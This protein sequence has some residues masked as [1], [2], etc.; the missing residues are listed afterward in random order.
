[1]DSGHLQSF[2]IVAE[3]GH[4]TRAA[5]RL[6]ITQPALTQQIKSLEA[7]VGTA[8]L[9]KAGRGVELTAAGRYLQKEGEIILRN[10][11]DVSQC[12]REMQGKGEVGLTLAITDVEALAFSVTDLLRAFRRRFPKISLQTILIEAKDVG[13]ALRDRRIDAA[14]GCS[15]V[16]ELH[17]LDRL[18]LRPA[19]PLLAVPADHRLAS[20]SSVDIASLAV[21][22]FV[23]LSNGELRYS[24]QIALRKVFVDRNSSPHILAVTPDLLVALNMVASGAGLALVP[25]SV[26]GLRPDA[27]RYLRLENCPELL[28]QHALYTRRVET[29]AAVQSLKKLARMQTSTPAKSRSDVRTMVPA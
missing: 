22:P 3:E 19:P 15:T 26:N 17:D 13:L 24:F 21:E 7:E 11:R 29:L 20:A 8:L 23:L 4:V 18:D 28:V 10:M 27:I 25:D 6:N 16:Q 9:R 12:A 14:L 1:M 2:C 5:K